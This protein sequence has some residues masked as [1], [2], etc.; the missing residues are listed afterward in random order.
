MAIGLTKG[1]RVGIWSPNRPEWVI[2]Q[3]ATAERGIV[4]VTINP[5]YR[6]DELDYAL[7]KVE[8]KAVIAAERFKTSD[9]I[10]MLEALA[11][12]LAT[13]EP[14]TLVAERAPHLRSVI[15]MGTDRRPGAYLFDDIFDKADEVDDCRA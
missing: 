5:A 10:A 8:C 3:F 2:A 12:E 13:C 15:F 6:P 9:Y 4:L 1:D 11:P 14:G 7:N